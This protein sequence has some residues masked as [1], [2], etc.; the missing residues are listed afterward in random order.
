MA[1]RFFNVDKSIYRNNMN[2]KNYFCFK[3]K[4]IVNKYCRSFII[5]D[6]KA[7]KN[8]EILVIVDGGL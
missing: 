7:L 2:V 1:L 4:K 5:E 8:V 3:G 6:P